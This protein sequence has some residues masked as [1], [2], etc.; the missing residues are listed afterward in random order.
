M[1]LILVTFYGVEG[2]AGAASAGAAAGAVA[3]G[4]GAV[5]GIKEAPE[6]PG[7]L[8]AG[9]LVGSDTVVDAPDD[10]S[11]VPPVLG[12]DEVELV[13]G[14]TTAGIAVLG[15]DAGVVVVFPLV[16]PAFRSKF[17]S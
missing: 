3:C 12:A 14:K 2:S 1:L 6:V 4:V 17:F 8:S 16:P 15:I 13:C 10:V 9:E 7:G 5:G 11:C